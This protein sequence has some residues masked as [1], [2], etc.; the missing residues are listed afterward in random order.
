[1]IC[2]KSCNVKKIF[3]ITKIWCI[4]MMKILVKIDAFGFIIMATIFVK[5][6]DVFLIKFISMYF[7]PKIVNS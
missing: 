2:P 7:I 1:V 4:I 6:D 3:D 5:F